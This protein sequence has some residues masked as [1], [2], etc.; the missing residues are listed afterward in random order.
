MKEL[1]STE[2]FHTLQEISQ[3]GIDKDADTLQNEYDVFANLIFSVGTTC[4][5]CIQN[6]PAD[7]RVACHNMLV[8]THCELS[9]LKRVTW[10]KSAIS[11]SYLEKAIELVD[12]QMDYI[13][14]VVD[15]PLRHKS[16]N[17]KWV[18]TLLDYV[19]W[20]YGL[21]EFLNQSGEKVSLKMMF[22]TF[23][24]IF[25]IEVQDYAQ[26]FRTIKSRTKGERTTFLDKQKKLLTERME[27]L[28]QTPSKK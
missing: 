18:G 11:F 2:F 19:E 7:N 10:K 8:Y 12:K 28:D 20:V 1:V 23:N 25:G 4:N 13:A 21:H 26:Y 9:D 15:C 14:D 6:E 24:P 27:K 17:L 3:K 22:E 5:E 16:L